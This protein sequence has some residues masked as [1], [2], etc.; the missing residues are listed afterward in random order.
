[1]TDHDAEQFVDRFARLWA[2]PDP[3]GYADLWH[4]DGLL[5]HPTMREPLAQERIPDYVRG[6]KALAPDISL[7]VDRWA[8]R[9]DTVLIEWTLTAS[10]DG[11]QATIHGTDRFT[12]RGDRATEGVAYFDTMP[13]WARIDPELERAESF[14]ERLATVLEQRDDATPQQ[15]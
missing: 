7:A 6:L 9:D 12:L 1:M 13:L 10:V 3:D 14:E 11:D 2:N 15:G 8:A 5:R 4:R